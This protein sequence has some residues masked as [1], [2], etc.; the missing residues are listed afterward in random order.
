MKMYKVTYVMA[1][2]LWLFAWVQPGFGA[3]VGGPVISHL[4]VVE[5]VEELSMAEQ[6]VKTKVIEFVHDSPVAVNVYMK[7]PDGEWQL[8][9]TSD[10]AFEGHTVHVAVPSDVDHA[11]FRVAS[12]YQSVFN[13]LAEKGSE[14]QQ[15]PEPGTEAFDASLEIAGYEYIDMGED[16][17]VLTQ[18]MEDYDEQSGLPVDTTANNQAM[19]TPDPG[20]AKFFWVDG[21]TDRVATWIMSNSGQ[22]KSYAVLSNGAPS[23]WDIIGIGDVNGDNIDDLLWRNT[24]DGRMAVW[25]MTEDGQQDSALVMDNTAPIG[26]EAQGVADVDGQNGID[27]IWLK[28]STGQIAVWFMGTDGQRS[29]ATIISN[30][31]P[32]G[33]TLQG[34][35]DVDHADGAELLWLKEST[36]QL[37]VWFLGTDGQRKSAAIMTNTAPSGWVISA[38]GDIN[39]TA[40]DDILWRNELDGRMAVWFLNTSGQRASAVVMDNLAV[41]GWNVCGLIN[42]DNTAGEDV[43]WRYAPTDQLAV[44]F[45]GTNGQRTNALVL[46]AAAPSTWEIDAMTDQ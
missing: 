28:E 21:S 15:L 12:D 4:R 27:I 37:A 35:M 2:A 14:I 9:K 42:V 6:D 29:S 16:G 8:I 33:W 32:T 31:A 20:H 3:A 24:T 23:G 10:P 25:F 34:V 1:F 45:M 7:V 13:A 41:P 17:V 19:A 5:Q 46:T 18:Q 39:N 26:W 11:W 44:W 30:I 43:I 22:R 40:G 36:G 38:L